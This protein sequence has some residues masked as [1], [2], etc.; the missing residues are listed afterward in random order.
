[1]SQQWDPH[2][3]S[4]DEWW[5]QL[6]SPHQDPPPTPDAD[7]VD[8]HF[9][10]VRTVFEG[11]APPAAAEEDAQEP[12]EYEAE[13]DGPER[14]PW[15]EDPWGTDDPP[16]G[17][18]MRLRSISEDSADSASGGGADGGGWTGGS[19]EEGPEY[20]EPLAEEERR[21]SDA[22]GA[23]G[24][25]EDSPPGWYVPDPVGDAQGPKTWFTDVSSFA[26]DE[27]EEEWE[28]A[29][30]GPGEGGAEDSGA[31][32]G[33]FG[34]WAAEEGAGQ[35][36]T[37]EDVPSGEG[38]YG[39]GG[40]YSEGGHS[41]GSSDGAGSETWY[42]GGG[43]PEEEGYSGY[44]YS[45]G[46]YSGEYAEGDEYPDDACSG[47]TDSN[48][49]TGS[50]AP[51][52]EFGPW[53]PE[54][55]AGAEGGDPHA[56]EPHAGEAYGAE[57]GGSDEGFADPYAA[58]AGAGRP[59][60]VEANPYAVDTGD[61][62][63]DWAG[64]A[65]ADPYAAEAGTADAGA[66]APGE[67]DEAG[68][69]GSAPAGAGSAPA[70]FGSGSWNPGFWDKDP[71]PA[72]PEESGSAVPDP[73]GASYPGEVP[74][75]R[76]APAAEAPAAPATT[77]PAAAGPPTPVPAYGDE[78]FDVWEAPDP[79][80]HVGDRPPTYAAEPTAWP[81]ADPERIETLTADTVLDGA[82]YGSLTLRAASL[83]GDS[84]R[85]RGQPR[86]DAVLTA[87]FG[88][89]EDAVL[90]LAIASGARTGEESHLAARTACRWIASAVGRNSDSLLDDLRSEHRGS[91]KAGL[92]R[93]TGRCFGQLRLRAAERG[94]QPEEYT[95][96]L[97]CLLLPAD[98][99]C[100]TRVFFGIGDGGFFRLR[101]G[102]WQ[103][104]DPQRV[105]QPVPGDEDEDPSGPAFRFRASAGRAGD[106]LLLCT[107]GLAAP[108]RG[109]PALAGLLAERW[110]GGAP[111]GLAGF[112]R[113]TQIRVKGYAEDRTAVAAWE[114]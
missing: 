10:D 7:S 69:R 21:E 15:A 46:E 5:T 34:P 90:L 64:A 70:A 23:S 106:T 108:L 17:P 100:R 104:L 29:A 73:R 78:D 101:E 112:L 94:Y 67:P 26:D 57:P 80:E 113:D 36:W 77:A 103:D 72:A 79:P 56:A 47:G 109:E 68:R 22:P 31:S 88:D 89:G 42:S 75:P 33:E 49:G 114:T 18:I 20:A 102:E 107:P 16:A 39:S 37:E 84:A 66:V 40:E 32:G 85:F 58:D 96:A 43:E 14:E 48:G 6:Y 4:E 98:P 87:R 76:E 35:H 83:R 3:R 59:G 53:N 45:G 62:G 97:R 86:R 52:G 8:E 51:G 91:L 28:D 111:P 81:S 38:D 11:G 50:A 1:M 93:L 82:Q 12:E 71:A 41:G 74:D 63:A 92:H 60:P 65:D 25:E 105:P 9:A 27:G 95:A 99:A 110:S 19:G 55:G 13:P 2:R 54:A 30:S 44:G 61:E 24:D